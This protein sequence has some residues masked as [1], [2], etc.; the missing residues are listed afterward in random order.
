[1]SHLNFFHDLLFILQQIS[2]QSAQ[3]SKMCQDFFV[4]GRDTSFNEQPATPE[5]FGLVSELA[6]T[7]TNLGESA[8]N[9]AE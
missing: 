8:V 9:P 5:K 2:E 4:L 6:L 7:F 1:M 3:L